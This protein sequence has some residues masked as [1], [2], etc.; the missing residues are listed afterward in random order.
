[1]TSLPRAISPE[2]A[3]VGVAQPPEARLAH[4]AEHLRILNSIHQSIL[5]APTPEAIAQIVLRHIPELL[6]YPQATVL[7]HNARDHSFTVLAANLNPN[8][9]PR[10][11]AILQAA[12][13]SQSE[14]AEFSYDRVTIISDTR[15]VPL[16]SLI[17]Q[18]FE[19][20]V[21]RA[22]L[23]L[24]LMVADQPIGVLN[25]Y[26]DEPRTPTQAEI[27]IAM[28]L[29]DILAVALQQALLHRVVN[30]TRERLH[31]LAR[32]QLELEE[33]QRRHMSRDLHDMVGQN[34]TALNMNLHA[35][36]LNL[37]ADTPDS[38][39]SR[40]E[41]SSQLVQE[42]VQRI[43]GLMAELRPSILDDL[44]LAP[45][46]RWYAGEFSKRSDLPIHVNAAELQPRLPQDTETALFRIAQEAL[47]NIAKH[48]RATAVWIELRELPDR[49][50][51]TISDDGVGFDFVAMRRDPTKT[52]VGLVDMRE[53]AEAIG[54]RIWV[55]C[56]P[57]MGTQVKVEVLK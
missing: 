19:R 45:A 41:D 6:S 12:T 37:P 14:Q 50:V 54:G 33:T 30:T 57:G 25:L 2:T 20:Q 51:L 13:A 1:M 47:T 32:R 18:V 43:R 28:Q 29:A 40:L 11:N 21:I 10:A 36:G 39:R 16:P 26:S 24:P 17:A 27:E 5:A 9:Q 42:I 56:E 38:V 55:E 52:G 22:V 23:N 8:N 15:Q 49:V 48:S 46:L 44:G 7:L 34:L 31:A 4:Y 35:I 53:R 3:S